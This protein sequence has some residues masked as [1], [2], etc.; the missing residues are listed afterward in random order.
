MATRMTSNS[1]GRSGNRTAPPIPARSTFRSDQVGSLLR[2]QSVKDARDRA[3]GRDA[4]SRPHPRCRSK[5]I[6]F[7]QAVRL[8]GNR[9]APRHL[10]WRLSADPAFHVDFLTRIDGVEWRRRPF[11]NVFQGLEKDNS[12]LVFEVTGKIKHVQKYRSRRFPVLA[13]CHRADREGDAARTEFRPCSRRTRCHR[14][15]SLS[16]P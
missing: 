12:P 5:T 4:L 1:P 9:R 11:P 6:A 10:R 7:G 14:S 8:P 16:R 2:P 3:R 15:G 13:A